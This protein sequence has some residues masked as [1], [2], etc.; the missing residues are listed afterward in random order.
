MIASQERMLAEVK[1]EVQQV[2]TEV[3]SEAQRVRAEVTA[4]MQQVRAE[5]TAELQQVRAE[6]QVWRA[7]L[8][9]TVRTVELNEAQ[10]RTQILGTAA[11]LVRVEQT[12]QQ[13][14]AQL[15]AKLAM[16]QNEQEKKKGNEEERLNEL[17]RERIEEFAQQLE[18]KEVTRLQ[19]HQQSLEEWL[20]ERMCREFD[21]QKRSQTEFNKKMAELVDK[22]KQ[23]SE[24]KV[25]IVLELC[26]QVAER[27]RMYESQ[28]KIAEQQ[29]GPE[30]DKGQREPGEPLNF[31]FGEVT[32][33]VS[34]NAGS[35]SV[36]T[37]SLSP[38]G[39][40]RSDAP[41]ELRYEAEKLADNDAMATSWRARYQKEK[42][43]VAAEAQ[44][45][46]TLDV[47]EAQKESALDLSQSEENEARADAHM[48]GGRR[49]TLLYGNSDENEMIEGRPVYERTKVSEALADA[50]GGSG[51]E[52]DMVLTLRDAA[53]AV[54]DVLVRVGARTSVSQ[55]RAVALRE[56]M[57]RGVHSKLV[58]K[59]LFSGK[60]LKDDDIVSTTLLAA[61]WGESVVY[62]Y[63][64][65]DS[66]LNSGRR[67]RRER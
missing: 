35:S 44:E 63:S 56:L 32:G 33:G 21:R 1:A 58:S 36:A 9:K 67:F 52:G 2:R 55:V 24:T 59:L 29:L 7:E 37:G 43:E 8:E 16:M 66:A 46:H 6:V 4:E 45:E 54:Q 14:V 5:V 10:L 13:E 18:E 23:E 3:T 64:I 51:T 38:A 50:S 30:L 31:N 27:L 19:E 60:F 41:E 61:T 22:L 42:I 15:C 39:C 47:A 26:E 57:R 53:G 28:L 48:V 34:T 11:G 49:S 12:L 65:R 20:A 62:W 40:L 17:M 25:T